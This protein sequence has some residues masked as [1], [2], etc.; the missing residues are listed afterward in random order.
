MSG[1]RVCIDTNV[2]L[3]VLNKEREFYS[4]S[5]QVLN[6]VDRGKLKAVIP[7]L[8]ISEIISGFYTDNKDDKATQFLSTI[9]SN[10][11]AGKNRNEASR[12]HDIGYFNT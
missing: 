10:T 9:I 2:F 6:A 5:K 11:N 1:I 3:S 8:V 7:T 12:L 4:S